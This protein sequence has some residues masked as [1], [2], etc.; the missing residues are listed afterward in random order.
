MTSRGRKI[1]WA[2]VLGTIAVASLSGAGYWWWLHTPPPLPTN[3]DDAIA[4]FHSPRYQRLPESRREAYVER[5][6]ELWAKLSEEERVA[7][8]E[9]VEKDP[10]LKAAAQ[11]AMQESMNSG[12]RKYAMASPEDRMKEIDKVIAVQEMMRLGGQVAQQAR[13]FGVSRASTQPAEG[14]TRREQRMNEFRKSMQQA[15]ERGNPQRQAYMMEFM[16]DLRK[17][18]VEKGLDPDPPMPGQRG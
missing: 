5:A 12:A 16:K 4:T 15:V 6:R 2:V 10:E 18:R 13:R 1:V 14:A 8:R 7:L 11:K 9:R 17:R 3:V